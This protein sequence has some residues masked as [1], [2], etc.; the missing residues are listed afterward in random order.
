MVDV[1]RRCELRTP[2]AAARVHLANGRPASIFTGLP[3]KL[4]RELLA[5]ALLAPHH[6]HIPKRPGRPGALQGV[7]P[8]GRGPLSLSRAGSGA[9]CRPWRFR[10]GPQRFDSPSG[11]TRPSLIYSGQAP[12]QLFYQKD[13]PNR[14]RPRPRHG[15]LETRVP[16]SHDARRFLEQSTGDVAP[17]R[18]IVRDS[19]RL[20]TQRSS[21][22]R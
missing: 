20:R 15:G 18:E 22:L 11:G 9:P 21:A 7:E 19:V 17:M 13:D 1:N 14:I 8:P 4:R 3:V 12:V 2:V 10:E 5:H 6:A 16:R